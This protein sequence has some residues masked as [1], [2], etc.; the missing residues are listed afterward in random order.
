MQALQALN[1]K[2]GYG[3]YMNLLNSQKQDIIECL[4]PLRPKKII[5]FGSYA[6]GTP[7]RD[8]DIDLYI[9]TRD[10]FIPSTFSETMNLKLKFARQLLEFR[11]KYPSDLFV[12]TSPMHE[13]FKEPDS[14]FAR[15]IMTEGIELL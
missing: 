9:V 2:N 10:E 3:V 15:K 4:K 13:K 11:K 7:D 1:T 5:L 8:S 14:S 6:W 12:H